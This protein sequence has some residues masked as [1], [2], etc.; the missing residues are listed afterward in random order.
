MSLDPVQQSLLDEEARLRARRWLRILL[1]FSL[2]IFTVVVWAEFPHLEEPPV[3]PVATRE[4]GPD[5]T[6]VVP[7]DRVGFIRLGLS[8]FQVEQKLGRGRA[9]PTQS[10]VLYRFDE[11]GLSCAVQRSQVISILVSNPK[12][13]TAQGL[14]VG[15]DP[16]VVVRELGD[17]YEWESI[18]KNGESEA[19]PKLLG[20]TLHYWRSGIHVRILEDRVESLLITGVDG[21]P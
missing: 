18:E 4:V 5:D 2:A 14:A 19:A 7:G 9:K 11:H 13:H 12:Y 6:L 10:A 21:K 17:V 15:S 1:I 20:Y 8:I 3:A 16:D